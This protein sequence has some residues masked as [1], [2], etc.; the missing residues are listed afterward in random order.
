MREAVRKFKETVE[1]NS[2]TFNK[3][4]SHRYFP[5]T[6]LFC[7]S[8]MVACFHVWQRVKVVTL[9]KEIGGLKQENAALLDDKKKLYSELASLSTASR[10]EQFAVDSLGL[11]PVEA[12]RLLTLERKE[13]IPSQPDE[14][15]QMMTAIKRI[16]DFLPVIEETRAKA[17]VVEDIKIDSSINGWEKK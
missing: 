11:K 10:I 14:L 5:I 6:V 1:I 9:A 15:S 12:D 7:L 8:L 4:R 17:G 2:S 16:A 13:I 3:I